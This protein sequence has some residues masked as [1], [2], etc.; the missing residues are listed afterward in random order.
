MVSAPDKQ[1]V[2]LARYQARD[3]KC[4]I[5]GVHMYPLGGLKKTASW[6]YAVLDEKYDM[7]REANGFKVNI[8]L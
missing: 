5:T 4:G 8:D 7:N 2:E 6:I 1:I 3:P